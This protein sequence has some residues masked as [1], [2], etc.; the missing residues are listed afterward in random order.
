MADEYVFNSSQNQT[1]TDSFIMRDKQFV[2]ISDSA[3]GSYGSSQVT[4]DLASFSNSSKT[5]SLLESFIVI[6]LGINMLLPNAVNSPGKAAENVYAMS[7]KSSVLHLIHSLELQLSNNTVIPIQPFLNELRNFEILTSFSG[8]DIQTHG[9]SIM[10]SKDECDTWNYNA[11]PTGDG[12]GMMNNRISGSQSYTTP[13]AAY[14]QGDNKYLTPPSPGLS[15]SCG[16]IYQFDPAVSDRSGS[17]GLVNTFTQNVGRLRRQLNMAVATDDTASGSCPLGKFYSA[18][19]MNTIGKTRCTTYTTSNTQWVVMAKI[20]LRFLHDFFI[21]CPL[22]KNAY[23]RLTLNTN[24]QTTA[25]FNTTDAGLHKAAG[26][27]INSV[28]GTYPFQI[29]PLSNA[30]HTGL[31]CTAAEQTI[32]ITS[33]IALAGVVGFPFTACRFYGCVGT[34]SPQMDQL[35]FSNPSKVVNYLDSMTFSMIN[36]I[37][38]GQTVNQLLCNGLS[39][40]RKCIIIPYLNAASN[41]GIAHTMSPFD[42]CPGTTC[43]AAISGL[44]VQ[45][46]GSNVF[47]ETQQYSYLNFMTQLRGMNSLCGGLDTGLNS[48]TISEYEYEN[49]YKYFVVDLSHHP[50]EDDDVAKSILVQFTN[51][52]RQNLD[53]RVH[54]VYERSLTIDVEKGILCV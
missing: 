46:S 39:R 43:P 21:K 52:N 41:G 40:I 32:T 5:L 37:S 47:Q 2:W 31:V 51:L 36:N 38:S 48:G 28:N 7:L 33:G 50:K 49:N 26:V 34:L 17:G 6:P 14:A 1:G 23:F 24:T 27:S 54:V 3:N 53:Y 20:P 25:T 10:F 44:Q 30:G 35:Y 11:T 45:I 18:N 8:E 42:S 12:F 13:A 19:A 16:N 15:G 29:S 22:L 9:P 4:F